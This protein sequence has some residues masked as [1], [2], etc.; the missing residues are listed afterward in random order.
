MNL[1]EQQIAQ[2][3]PREIVQAYLTSVAFRL[4]A[5]TLPFAQQLTQGGNKAFGEVLPSLIDFTPV[6]MER[7]DQLAVTLGQIQDQHE[8]A[9]APFSVV[10]SAN[11][12]GMVGNRGRKLV[13]ANTDL[14]ED[15]KR[16]FGEVPFSYFRATYPDGTP[17]GRIREDQVGAGLLSYW[18]LARRMNRAPADILLATVDADTR[19]VS[20]GHFGK[21]QQAYAESHAIAWAGQPGSVLHNRLDGAK[22]PRIN[23]LVDWYNFCT[24]VMPYDIPEHHFAFNLGAFALGGGYASR[25]AL[26][27]TGLW[28]RAQQAVPGGRYERV[29]LAGITAEVSS[30]R[31][32]DQASRNEGFTYGPLT[33]KSRVPTEPKKDIQDEGFIRGLFNVLD[34]CFWGIAVR[35]YNRPMGPVADKPALAAALNEAVGALLQEAKAT[36]APQETYAV[37]QLVVKKKWVELAAM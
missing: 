7:E 22:F 3:T 28:E 36:D 15:A 2:R 11:R 17:I 24:G 6:A 16:S 8:E 19:S 32:V 25:P 20:K 14:L 18:V 23:R 9:R 33:N 26:E 21:L 34:Q 10:I 30:R 12:P 35:Y 37:I 27:H 4:D 13:A 29:A 5:D 31:L 1:I